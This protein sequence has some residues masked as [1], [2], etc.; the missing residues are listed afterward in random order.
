MRIRLYFK[1]LVCLLTLLISGMLIF[2]SAAR[3]DDTSHIIKFQQA[4]F[5]VS[6]AEQPPDQ[7]SWKTATL[8]DEWQNER[9][10]QGDNG[11]Y[12]FEINWSAPPTANWGCYLPR[13]N[14]NAAVYLNGYYL[15]DG[16]SFAEPIARNWNRPL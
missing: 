11:W 13:L 16:G 9:Y 15:G 10:L 5:L 6:A 4:A 1:L 8:P 14:M 3:A 2:L 7:G 12:R